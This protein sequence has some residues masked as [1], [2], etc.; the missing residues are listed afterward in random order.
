MAARDFA[1]FSVAQRD[2]VVDLLRS[3]RL[4]LASA[5]APHALV[6][7]AGITSRELDALNF[8][9]NSADA[10][11][12][13][14]A[15][16]QQLA[17]AVASYQGAGR[18]TIDSLHTAG[19]AAFGEG[20]GMLYHRPANPQ[21][22]GQ[23]HTYAGP[24]RRRYDPRTLPLGLTQVIGHISD[25]KCRSLLGEWATGEPDPGKLRHL[26]SD[27]QEVVYQIGELP[28]LSGQ[29]H[30]A[31]LIFVD[32]GMSRVPREHYQVFELPSE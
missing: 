11:A 26:V 28:T 1:A 22:T 29:R 13:A 10:H 21:R 6:C 9:G 12:V 16:N 17:A 15:V 27:G 30:E 8:A 3:G 23:P 25:A 32:G 24:G 7:H 2:L 31:R 4:R 20:G 5:I 19:D 14:A 18:L